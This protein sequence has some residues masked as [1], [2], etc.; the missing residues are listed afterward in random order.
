M[1]YLIGFESISKLAL[2]LQ[3]VISEIKKQNG[4]LV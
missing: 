4:R 3:E 2:T 1:R